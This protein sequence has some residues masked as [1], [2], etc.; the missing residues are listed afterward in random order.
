[1]DFDKNKV[2]LMAVHRYLSERCLRT[3]AGGFMPPEVPVAPEIM[4]NSP[5][6]GVSAFL[7]WIGDDARFI[8]AH[9][10]DQQLHTVNPMLQKDEGVGM[11]YK[12][13]RDM[14]IF[15]TKRVL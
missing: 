2:D 13:G 9:E 5:E 4:N 1:M 8:P 15:T 6:G 14:I 10:I 7:N 12:S 11:A 3:Q